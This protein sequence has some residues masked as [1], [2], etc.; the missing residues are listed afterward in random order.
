MLR[1]QKCG[2]SESRSVLS[3][4]VNEVNVYQR[5]T[6][7]TWP[8]E[9]SYVSKSYVSLPKCN[10]QRGRRALHYI[11]IYI[12]FYQGPLWN[13]VIFSSSRQW[14]YRTVLSKLPREVAWKILHILGMCR[15]HRWC[16]D[17]TGHNQ[18]GGCR[19]A[20]RMIDTCWSWPS[21]SWASWST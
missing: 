8:C 13:F 15:P 9:P 11:Y 5:Y 19:G 17:G 10:G 12:Y 4:I 3:S 14:D 21:R 7:V 6:V 1:D 2:K 16:R 18:E 20:G